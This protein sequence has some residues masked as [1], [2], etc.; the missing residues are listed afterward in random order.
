MSELRRGKPSGARGRARAGHRARGAAATRIHP[1]RL[2]LAEL[3]HEDTREEPYRPELVARLE[4]AVRDG[5][6]RPDARVI[7]DAIVSRLDSLF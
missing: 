5:V 7:A 3:P 1:D 6:Y 2:D 4:R